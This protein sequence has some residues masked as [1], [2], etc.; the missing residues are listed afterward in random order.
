[1]KKKKLTIKEKL[2]NI[3]IVHPLI[4]TE[5]ERELMEK[6]EIIERLEKIAKRLEEI[7]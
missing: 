1:M 5:T 6:Q 2:T 4:M 3:R 7:T